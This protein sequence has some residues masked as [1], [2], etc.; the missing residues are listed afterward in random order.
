MSGNAVLTNFSA[1]S[2]LEK[3]QISEVPNWFWRGRYIAVNSIIFYHGVLK[4]RRSLNFRT[5]LSDRQ[6]N[7]SLPHVLLTSTTQ[8]SPFLSHWSFL[9]PALLHTCETFAFFS[10]PT[11]ITSWMDFLK[12]RERIC[13]TWGRTG[14]SMVGHGRAWFKQ[15]L[16]EFHLQQCCLDMFRSV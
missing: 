6:N 3:L 14:I 13:N 8:A 16:Q 5:T 12:T 15:H 2:S 9:F 1:A 7:L 4:P 11:P 10:E